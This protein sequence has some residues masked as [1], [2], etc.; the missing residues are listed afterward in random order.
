MLLGWF[1]FCKL[2]DLPL[3]SYNLCFHNAHSGNSV[4]RDDPRC[5][6]TLGHPTG[7]FPSPRSTWQPSKMQ[8]NLFNKIMSWLQ[9]TNI[10][11]HPT[12]EAFILLKQSPYF[13]N[14][15]K[16]IP[17]P[18][19]LRFAGTWHQKTSGPFPTWPFVVQGHGGHCQGVAP[20]SPTFF[21]TTAPRVVQSDLHLYKKADWQFR[22]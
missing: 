7:T 1:V 18:N 3:V 22:L 4:C 15:P 6:Q 10:S 5:P 11:N 8:K 2:S 19:L 16:S 13:I 14:F 12:L 9:E 17:L 20:K 21:S